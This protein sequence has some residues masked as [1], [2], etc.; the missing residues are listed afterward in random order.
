MKSIIHDWNDELS[1]IILDNCR[2]ALPKTGTLL[3]V[4]RLMPERP[5]VNDVHREQALS[6]LTI[7]R[8]PGGRER[9]ERMY[10]QLLHETGFV[11]KAT[12]PVGRFSIVE[13]RIA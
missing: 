7:L 5:D 8:G 10:V 6:D 12:H 4:E 13:A 11:H 1:L 9:T 3:L 2:K